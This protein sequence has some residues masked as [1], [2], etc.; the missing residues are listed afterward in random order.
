MFLTEHIKI[1]KCFLGSLKP[2]QLTKSSKIFQRW[3]SKHPHH[4]RDTVSQRPH[5]AFHGSPH[6]DQKK[7]G[8]SPQVEQETWKRRPS[9]SSIWIFPTKNNQQLG[10]KTHICTFPKYPYCHHF[11]GGNP[12][13][14]PGWNHKFPPSF[15]GQ[16]SKPNS[17]KA[18]TFSPQLGPIFKGSHVARTQF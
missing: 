11:M 10:A 6:W 9:Y 7:D 18:T 1:P 3:P 2:S 15:Q 17:P 13:K 16:A 5:A 4:C 8:R 12:S 14:A